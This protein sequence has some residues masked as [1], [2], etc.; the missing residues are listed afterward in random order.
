MSSTNS[1]SGA[2]RQRLDL[3]LAVAELAVSAGL[4]LVPA[5]RLGRRLDRLA[6]R[7]ARRLEVDVDA[8][9]PLQL[10][11]R[12]LDVQLSL[13]R[14]QQFLGLRIAADS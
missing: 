3:D 7:N 2:A 8:E 1:K 10:R 13:A 12:H 4:L 11:D 6:V 5:V 14:E 9:P